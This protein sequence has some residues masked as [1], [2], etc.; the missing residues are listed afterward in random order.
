[1]KKLLTVLLFSAVIAA[2][3]FSQQK[4][5]LV[6]GNGAYTGTGMSRLANPVNDAND[7]TAALQG[8]GFTVD[9]VL[10]GNLDQ[11]ESAIML[12]KN[13]L[14]VSKNSYGF[15]FYAGHG[16]Q[17][18]GSNYLIP[19]GAS[20]P[21]EN[22][23]RE[24]AVSVQFMLSE[25]NDAGNDLNVVVLDACRDNPFSWARSGSRGLTVESNQPADSI[26]VYATSAGSTAADGTGRNGLF[27][28]QL[29]KNLKTP[30]LEVKD[31]FNRTGAD[32]SQA[33]G[34]KQIP[35]IYSQFFGTAY[36]GALPAATASVPAPTPQ[37]AP[38][39]ASQSAPAAAV[40]PSPTPAPAV[41]PAPAPQPAPA[42]ASSQT[43]RIGDR[44]PASGIVFYDKGNNTGGWR[45]LEAAPVDLQL[46]QWGLYGEDI[47]GTETGIGS[48]KRNT[49]LI[50]AALNRKGE[51][52]RA[53]QLCKA[54]TLNGYSDWFL[55]S[56]DELDLMYKNLASKGLGSFQTGEDRTTWTH[57]YWSSSKNDNNFAWSQYFS[58]GRQGNNRKSTT[59]SV[60]AVRA[61]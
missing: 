7:V 28:S 52:G 46:A 41:Q 48:G 18:G 16:V 9:K 37:P 2:P 17:S 53:A 23:L 58:N 36:L 4:Y 21:S 10:D 51:T 55:P 14:S 19:V 26:I 24:R 57:T 3:G 38:A 12:L 15:F 47:R 8:L 34:R 44:G 13:R 49:E 43:Y 42:A 25:L 31:I 29:L 40:Q 11:M 27:T 35:A 22:S 6:I 33:S 61:F 1:M 5:A 39:P 60:R 32:V 54:Y 59:L 30:G 56:K 50:I 20:I 45:Y